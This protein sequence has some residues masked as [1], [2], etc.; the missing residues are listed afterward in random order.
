MPDIGE[1]FAILWN[2]NVSDGSGKAI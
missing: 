2:K 1:S